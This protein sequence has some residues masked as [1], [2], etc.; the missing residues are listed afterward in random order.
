MGIRE[1]GDGSTYVSTQGEHAE[2]SAQCAAHWGNDRFA[3]LRPYAETTAS[4]KSA[5]PPSLPATPP[6]TPWSCGSYPTLTDP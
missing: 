5:W 6:T 3:R 4:R 2:L 1:V